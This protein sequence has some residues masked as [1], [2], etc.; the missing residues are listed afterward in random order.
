[1][2]DLTMSILDGE[3]FGSRRV[4]LGRS[5]GT[6]GMSGEREFELQPD[7]G[8][9]SGRFGFDLTATELDSDV[10]FDS[11]HLGM[12]DSLKTGR[13]WRKNGRF[14]RENDVIR[15]V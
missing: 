8:L 2:T 3:C 12:P 1:M 5:S 10:N 6:D 9:G 14:G 13:K 7:H 4:R 15:T 11:M